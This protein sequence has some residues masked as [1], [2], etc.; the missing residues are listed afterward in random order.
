[1]C[2]VISSLDAS[3]WSSWHDDGFW[4]S[5]PNRCSPAQSCRSWSPWRIRHLWEHPPYS[6]DAG[7]AFGVSPCNPWA[8]GSLDEGLKSFPSNTQLLRHQRHRSSMAS[9][10]HLVLAS[11]SAAFWSNQVLRVMRSLR[12]MTK[13]S[14]NK[15]KDLRCKNQIEQFDRQTSFET[16][17][18]TQTFDTSDLRCV[19]LEAAAP[20]TF[21]TMPC[22]LMKHLVKHA[23]KTPNTE[24]ETCLTEKN[25][26]IF[27]NSNI[28]HLRFVSLE[29]AV[30]LIF[31]MP[32]QIIYRTFVFSFAPQLKR[33]TG[34]VICSI[35][36]R[37]IQLPSSWAHVKSP[38]TTTIRAC[39]RDLI[40]FVSSNCSVHFWLAKKLDPSI[41]SS[42]D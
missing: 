15:D 5:R 26:D 25:F 13:E 23:V 24:T 16:Q 35:G 41:V 21:A 4:S 8:V 29:A 1:M 22:L 28:R 36:T 19:S 33:W 14:E 6:Q 39:E 40:G 3:L 27:W 38:T 2:F 18:Q 12:Q 42:K 32:W 20:V 10:H 17:T 11:H 7:C 31:Y 30:P 34:C 37:V 9:H